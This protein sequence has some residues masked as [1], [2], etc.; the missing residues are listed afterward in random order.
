MNVITSLICT[1]IGFLFG[2]CFSRLQARLYRRNIQKITRFNV[3]NKNESLRVDAY[4]ANSG[5]KDAG[6]SVNLGY[7]FEYMAIAMLETQ[8]LALNKCLELRSGPAPATKIEVEGLSKDSDLII[9]GGPFHNLLTGYIFGLK[10]EYH[11]VPFYFDDLSVDVN[12]Q[13]RGDE[14]TLV[15]DN[16]EPFKFEENCFIPLKDVDNKFYHTDYALILN[17][18]NPFNPKKRIIS[19]IGCRSIGVYGAAMYFNKY[20]NE[21][22]KNIKY[23]QYA[24]I[25]RVNGEQDNI[26]GEPRFLKSVE[27]NSIDLGNITSKYIKDLKIISVSC[28]Y[29]KQK[30]E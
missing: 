29:K 2:I 7:P 13:I 4:Y 14:A 27:L 18:R 3:N 19:F 21:I 6:E 24:I 26:V 16:G 1:G 11:N 17:V 28:N 15:F 8:L 10:K 9:L 5:K 12:G 23:D 30:I 25:I 20:S 22:K